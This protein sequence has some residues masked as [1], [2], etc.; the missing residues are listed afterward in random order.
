MRIGDLEDDRALQ[1]LQGAGLAL[2]CGAAR[3][4]VRSQVP[5]LSGLLRTLYG[6]FPLQSSD[7]VFDVTVE[8][9]PAGGLRRFIRPQVELL[10][11]GER[12]FDPFP[13]DTPIPLLE[14]GVNYAF[15]TRLSC[16]LL[17]HAGV[18]ARGNRA[19]VLPALP[20][21]GK[22]TLTAALTARGYRLLSDE[23]G[24]VRLTDSA[25][26]PMLRPV[27]LK[28]ES[29]DVIE[30]FAPGCTIGAR[31][32]RTRKGTVAHL[33]PDA[34]AVDARHRPAQP[35]LIVFPRYVADAPIEIQP[36]E[37]SR[38]FSRLAVNSFNHELLGPDSFDAL[39]RLV[40]GCDCYQLRY[41]NLDEAIDQVTALLDRHVGPAPLH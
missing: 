27:A 18:V 9:R 5:R 10:L 35:A 41:G 2:D 6:A 15:A 11:D 19:V 29:I 32:P 34:I 31:Y 22:S 13:A 8:M 33:A 21:S 14:W 38:A 16:Y 39:T 17:L 4:R 30:R 1:L 37:R 26:L 3:M 24:V 12:P 20:G 40:A 25:L 7:G 36:V 23:F 28:N